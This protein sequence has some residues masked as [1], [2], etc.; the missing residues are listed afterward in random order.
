LIRYFVIF[1]IASSVT[2]AQVSSGSL[3]GDVRDP[4]KQA[5]AE[6][7]VTAS[8]NATGFARTSITGPGGAYRIDN[9]LPGAYTL[10]ARRVGFKTLAVF[11]ITVEIDQKA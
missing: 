5:V 2:L 6:V 7:M 8:N 1:A 10:T 9:L 3:I 4:K 11:P